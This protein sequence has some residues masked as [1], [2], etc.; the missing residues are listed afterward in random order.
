MRSAAAAAAVG[1]RRRRRRRCVGELSQLAAEMDDEAPLSALSAGGRCAEA[2]PMGE[3]L[4]ECAAVVSDANL[5]PT[6]AEASLSGGCDPFARF[7]FSAALVSDPSPS[8]S[9]QLAACSD[10]R[11]QQQPSQAPVE[12]V[13]AETARAPDE[14]TRKRARIEGCALARSPSLVHQR[15]SPSTPVEGSRPPSILMQTTPP[16][17]IPLSPGRRES[18][19]APMGLCSEHGF[20]I[21]IIGDA[22]LRL[23]PSTPDSCPP[24][25]EASLDQWP[26]L[27]RVCGS[28]AWKLADHSFA[29]VMQRLTGRTVDEPPRW[30]LAMWSAAA[31]LMRRGGGAAEVRSRYEEEVPALMREEVGEMLP[32]QREAVRFGILR[33]GRLLCGDE[34]GLGKTLTALAVTFQYREE[35]PVLVIC[36]PTLR[37]QWRSQILH[38]LRHAVR[39]EDV[40][41]VMTGKA[42]VSETA[43]FVVVPYSLLSNT[44][45]QQKSD[46]GDF[47]VVIC[48]E[49][50]YIKEHS[51]QRTKAALPVLQR[52][53]RAVLL[54]GTPSLNHAAEL[55]PQVQAI[56][57]TEAIAFRKFAERY[58][59]LRRV[60]YGGRHFEKWTGVK[61]EDELSV[62]LRQIMIRRKKEDVLK[63]LPKMRRQRVVVS[64]SNEASL[65]VANDRL[66]AAG[67][68]G[69]A[70]E[71]LPS[72]E[73]RDLFRLV[74]EAKIKSTQEYIAYLLE[75]LQ[76]KVLLFGHHSIMMDAAEQTLR[77]QR[78][79]FIRIDGKTSQSQRPGLVELFQTNP[80]VTVALLSI[81]CC[82][83]GLNLTAASTVVFCELYW[84]P[85][86]MEQC[87]A[88]AHRMGQERM[89]DVHYLVVEGSVDERAFAL[90]S[91]KKKATSLMLDGKLHAFN[92]EETVNAQLPNR[93]AA[94]S[95]EE[96]LQELAAM[97]TARVGERQAEKQAERAAKQAERNDEV[98]AKRDA[99]AKA[100]TA[101]RAETVRARAAA[102]EAQAGARRTPPEEA[103]A[104]ARR[105]PTDVAEASSTLPAGA[106]DVESGGLARRLGRPPHSSLEALA[107][108]T[109]R[110]QREPRLPR[111]PRQP[112]KPRQPR[113]LRQ[114]HGQAHPPANANDVGVGSSAALASASVPA[115]PQSVAASAGEALLLPQA[116]SRR[117]RC[118]RP[119]DVS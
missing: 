58:A 45:L 91:E 55:H 22:Q 19:V 87:E 46:G 1:G 48:D 23:V 112:R 73:V 79:K 64:A 30:V 25:T 107:S 85:G 18:P 5:F 104:K 7:A 60:R 108:T 119:I 114:P 106:G 9:S 105:K 61:R 17:R 78:V 101:R 98:T 38:W 31:A 95:R 72:D 36:P 37:H 96:Q 92:P 20:R 63:Q 89:V 80:E 33:G 13:S 67:V 35:W 90:L 43:L 26:E 12:R 15:S 109:A 10:P 62:L 56:L 50:H 14:V 21:E 41:L 68:L 75:G 97:K 100:R 27:S 51:S 65:R 52:A 76:G 28:L 110:R 93:P 32:Y 102:R 59:N 69:V 77:S 57:G 42:V 86:I 49:S 54:S 16:T 81:T 3:P 70:P 116:V 6:T 94:S 103:E 53:K 29:L 4:A 39:L 113:E 115:M 84:V 47:Q 118:K 74:C 2:A 88:R 111:A 44:Q 40:Q 83:E 11:D 99:K 34:M 71:D 82:C 8:A 117:L 24:E 66:A